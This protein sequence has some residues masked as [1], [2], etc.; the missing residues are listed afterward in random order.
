MPILR[1]FAYW[2]SLFTSRTSVGG[3]LF[4]EAYTPNLAKVQT[5][6]YAS[7]I[8]F[9]GEVETLRPSVESF[10]F[11]APAEGVDVTVILKENQAHAYPLIEEKLNATLFKWQ[12]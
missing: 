1:I 5:S 10:V 9:I 4:L 3:H 2:T 8:L 11:K 6:Q 12:I 7:P